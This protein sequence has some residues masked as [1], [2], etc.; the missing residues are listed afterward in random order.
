MK[1]R[2]RG[3]PPP[4]FFGP[5]KDFP[6]GKLNAEDEGGLRIGITEQDGVVII[7]FGTELTWL[8]LDKASAIEFAKIILTRAGAKKIEV[9][10]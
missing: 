2:F 8:G 3:R 10:L 1:K 6:R 7:E 9:T 5:T 4:G